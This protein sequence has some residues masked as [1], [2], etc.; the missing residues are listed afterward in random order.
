MSQKTCLIR[1]WNNEFEQIL[2][3]LNVI[4]RRGEDIILYVDDD[5]VAVEVWR[6]CHDIITGEY[7]I[8][9]SDSKNISNEQEQ[10]AN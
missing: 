8:V 1:S 9:V 2:V 7:T 5:I 4:P 6:V 3:P 10:Q